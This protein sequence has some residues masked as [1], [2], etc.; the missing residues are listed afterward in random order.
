[1]SRGA[2]AGESAVRTAM[3]VLF[4]IVLD[5]TRTVLRD[6]E[7]II[8]LVLVCTVLEAAVRASCGSMVTTG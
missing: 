5:D 8:V 2:T 1:M 4:C 6:A 3:M 7:P